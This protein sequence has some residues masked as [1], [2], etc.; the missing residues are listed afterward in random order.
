[1]EIYEWASAQFM[2]QSKVKTFKYADKFQMPTVMAT[3][4]K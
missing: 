2:N 3:A 1:M 4:R